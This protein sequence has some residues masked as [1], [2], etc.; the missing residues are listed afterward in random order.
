MDVCY[1][2]TP[3]NKN[4]HS[5]HAVFFRVKEEISLDDAPK[6]VNNRFIWIEIGDQS[7]ETYTKLLYYFLKESWF[8]L[9]F[10]HDDRMIW[11]R[12]AQKHVDMV[13]PDPQH[14]LEHTVR[15][16]IRIQTNVFHPNRN[17]RSTICQIL[18]S[19]YPYKINCTV[20]KVLQICFKIR[21][22]K[23]MQPSLL[24]R[25]LFLSVHLTLRN[26]CW[27]ML[28]PGRVREELQ[29][30]VV[31]RVEGVSRRSIVAAQ[32]RLWKS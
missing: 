1:L 6:R 20:I 23:S 2:K 28:M 31:D 7:G 24:P 9:Q 3:K 8:F 29:K 21:T 5:I 25:P 4:I 12:E 26:L 27:F 32:F 16:V 19:S 30:S 11:L 17:T 13:D 18:S 10:W 15:A 14:C 22:M